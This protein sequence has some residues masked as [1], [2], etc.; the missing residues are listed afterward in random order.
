LNRK[1]ESYF[2]IEVFFLLKNR[3]KK[4]RWE[5]VFFTNQNGIY[6]NNNGDAPIF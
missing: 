6:I 1:P 4:K 3:N 5:I 2:C